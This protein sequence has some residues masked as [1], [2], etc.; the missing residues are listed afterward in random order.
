MP[1]DSVI[2]ETLNE[3]MEARGF[4]RL[5]TNDNHSTQLLF[6][7]TKEEKIVIISNSF[8]KLTKDDVTTCFKYLKNENATIGII[9]CEKINPGANSQIKH[10]SVVHN[11]IIETFEPSELIINITK[12]VLTPKHVKMDKNSAKEFKKT[13]GV[14]NIAVLNE[15]D[16]VCRFYGFRSGDVIS[17]H[18]EN[19]IDP[20][21]PKFIFHRIVK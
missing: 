19:P 21:L 15:L 17:I 2:L 6:T 4:L 8:E 13:F 16:P 11:I 12:H 9:I 5:Q 1:F 3:M 20:T 10:L 14:K 18:R 7:E